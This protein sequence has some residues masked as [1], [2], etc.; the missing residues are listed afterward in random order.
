[1][2][3]LTVPGGFEKY[4]EEVA[5]LVAD[6]PSWPPADMAPLLALMAKY[7]TFPPPRA[8]GLQAPADT[9]ARRSS[10]VSASAASLSGR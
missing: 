9:S 3:A 5:Q 4:L 1:M 8:P 6:S 7:D 2:L 10:M